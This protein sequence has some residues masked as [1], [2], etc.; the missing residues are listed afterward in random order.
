LTWAC[1]LH[2]DRHRSQKNHVSQKWFFIRKCANWKFSFQSMVLKAIQIQELKTLTPKQVQ[3]QI[4]TN[5]YP[6][7]PQDLAQCFLSKNTCQC[8]VRMLKPLSTPI[9]LLG[10][11]GVKSHPVRHNKD[12][13]TITISL[14]CF[15]HSSEAPGFNYLNFPSFPSFYHIYTFS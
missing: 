2:Q 10:Q 6:L 11:S 5:A 15:T 4:Q 14:I 13:A 12:K 3:D 7:S 1:L 8:S 9:W